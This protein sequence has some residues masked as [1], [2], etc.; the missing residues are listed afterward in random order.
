MSLEMNLIDELSWRGM[1]QDIMPGTKEQLEKEMT[2]AYIGFD[3]TADSLHIG[4]LVPILLLV[5]LQRAGHQPIALVGGATGMVGDPSGKSE[6]RNLLDEKTLERNLNGIRR[7][8]EKYLEFDQSK[9][10]AAVMANNYDWFR[11]MLFIDF[12]RDVGKH[13]T[14]NYMMAK[15][16]VRKR[17]EGETGISYTEFAY[18]LMQGYDFYWL[19]THHNCK[20]QMGG[21]DQWGNITTGTEL[22]RRK[23]GGEAFAFTCP[24]ITK[25][26]G[27]KFGKT[28]KGNVW[29]DPEKT[30]PYQFY[31]F[32]LNAADADAIKWIR[33]FTFLPK[34]EIDE[35]ISQHNT[36]PEQRILQKRLAE[37]V[38]LFVHGKEE[39]QKAIET[40]EKLF[41]AQS[42]SADSLTIEDLETMEGVVKFD[43]AKEKIESGTD[44]ISFL[45]E[46]GIFPSK[47]EARKMVQNGGVSINRKKVENVQLTVDS[48]LLLHEKYLLVQKGKKNYYLV[49]VD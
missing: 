44:I 42:A 35:L 47:G 25:A 1:I 40:T 28:E 45:A 26:D 37:E 30:S 24:L 48:S 20:M 33:I 49:T 3:P 13:I 39:Y 36:H 10:N 8:L 29:L 12:L 27:G 21:S 18:Q 6:E 34:P 43:Y 14:V 41:S 46:A 19:Y 32:W 7:Q 16:S 5:H 11:N 4:S 15:D 17:I 2:T 38:T 23:A 9:K 22:V 31:Q